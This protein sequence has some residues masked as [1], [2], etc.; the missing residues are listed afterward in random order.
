MNENSPNDS[1]LRW[2]DLPVVALR[3]RPSSH[4]DRYS[5]QVAGR[6]CV[7][8]CFL[9]HPLSGLL[10]VQFFTEPN[11]QILLAVGRVIHAHQQSRRDGRSGS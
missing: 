8:I 4:V 11:D 6:E 1:A 3:S 10:D 5:L 9:R 2:T 7:S